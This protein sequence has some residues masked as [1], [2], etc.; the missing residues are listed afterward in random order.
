MAQKAYLA[1]DLGAESGRTIVGILNHE[2]LALHETHRFLNVPRRLPTGLHWDLTGLWGHILDGV[3]LSAAWAAERGVGLT[4]L[5]VDTWG[6]DWALIGPSGELLGLPHSHRDEAHPPAYQR[7][8]ERIG[9]E[10]LYTATGIQFMPINTIGQVF[11]RHE[12]EPALFDAADR[13]LFIPDLLHYFFTGEKRVEA[14]IASTSQMIDARTGEWASGLMEKLGLPVHMLGEIVKPGT[15]LGPILPHIAEATGAPA[16]LPVILPATHDTASAVAAVPADP[17]TNWAYLSSGTWSL[18][19]TEIDA[20]CLTGAAREVP[21]TNEGGV[22][23]TIR[24]LKNIA[25]LWL[26][27]E[28]RRDYAGRGQE[29][30]YEELTERAADAEPFR[31]LVDTDHA[32]FVAPSDMPAK[33][34]AFARSTDQP[35]PETVGQFIRCCLESLA[36][37]YRLTLDRLERVLGR[38]FD[39]LHVV[40]GGGKNELLNQMTADAIGR[41]VIVGPAEATGAGNV[42]VQAMGAGDVADLA[43]IRRIVRASFSPTTYEPRKAAEWQRAYE[44]FQE[45][46]NI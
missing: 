30:S 23:G 41:C 15:R 9:R 16:D 12:S 17:S 24:F 45:I 44:R 42:L 25:G 39:V 14:T 5:G 11:A 37:T 34:A 35:A 20:P 38:R 26:V 1:I 4:S 28:T 31:T 29:Y 18:M 36:L 6:V 46:L 22:D 32:P 27:Q 10:P 43:H 33:I 7:M 2:Q 3:R 40:G 13:L 19:G 21:F 8:L